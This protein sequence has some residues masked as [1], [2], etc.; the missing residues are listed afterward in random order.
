MR[1]LRSRDVGAVLL[2]ILVWTTHA[3]GYVWD[4]V[5]DSSDPYLLGERS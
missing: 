2:L 1:G 4:Q 5:N 3:R